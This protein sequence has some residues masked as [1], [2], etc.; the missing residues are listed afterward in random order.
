MSNP[1]ATGRN[2]MRRRRTSCTATTPAKAPIGRPEHRAARVSHRSMLIDRYAGCHRLGRLTPHN[3]R[4]PT[5]PL[6]HRQPGRGI[7]ARDA[8]V[9]WIRERLVAARISSSASR[10]AAGRRRSSRREPRT[11]RLRPGHRRRRRRDHP[12]GAQRGPDAAGAGLP[13]RHRPGRHRATTSLAASAC[14]PMRPRRGRWRI[15]RVRARS[16]SRSRRTGRDADAGS[17]RREASA[18]TRRSRPPWRAVAAGRRAR[19][20][21][22]SRR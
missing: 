14:R 10:R 1:D 11:R 20:G 17:R 12:G 2:S 5:A 9:P 18:S 19:P 22:C 16:T 4:V 21:I 15:G 6:D 13:T 7:G 8:A 3:R